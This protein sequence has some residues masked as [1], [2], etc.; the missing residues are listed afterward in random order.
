MGRVAVWWRVSGSG[1]GREEGGRM[2][3][4]LLADGYSVTAGLVLSGSYQVLGTFYQPN[5]CHQDQ[6]EG[7]TRLEK[8][9]GGWR[10]G[11]CLAGKWHGLVREF[12]SEKVVQFIGR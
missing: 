5:P 7:Y 9:D 4:H 1:G 11:F 10:E 2:Q 6:P 3:S 12:N 8:E